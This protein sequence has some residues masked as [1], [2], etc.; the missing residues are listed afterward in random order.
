MS[1]SPALGVLSLD[2]YEFETSHSSIVSSKV[3]RKGLYILLL[4]TDELNE[5]ILFLKRRS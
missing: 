4:L 2:D 1:V 3:G 5:Q